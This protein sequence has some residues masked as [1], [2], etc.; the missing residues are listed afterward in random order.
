V[1]WVISVSVLLLVVAIVVAFRLRRAP[2][3]EE[4]KSW[5]SV[6]PPPDFDASESMRPEKRVQ[7]F[8]MTSSMAALE[9]PI[10]DPRDLRMETQA[11][12]EEGE[13]AHDM[14]ILDSFL[15]DVRDSLGADEAVYWRWSK[16]RDTLTPGAWSTPNAQRPQFFDM[17]TW[18]ALV[19][20]AAEGR[21]LSF[22]ADARVAVTRLAAAPVEL[23]GRLIGVLSVARAEGLD[24]GREHLKQW[25]P[26]HAAQVGRLVSLFEVRLQM[27][28]HMRHS[29]AL[30][31]AAQ[32]VQ[33]HKS[34][35]ALNKAICETTLQVTSATEAALVRWR[36]D[37]EKGWVQFA[38][39]GLRHKAPFPIGP[40]S[41]VA[42]TCMNG[43]MFVHDDVA[44][45]SGV[46][47][48][49]DN[50][51]AWTKGALAIV[52]LELEN[53][54]IGAIVA[55]APPKVMIPNEEARNIALLGALA[56]TSL[57]MVWEI[58]EVS[59]RARTDALTGLANRRAFDEQ[60]SQLLA[61]ADRFGHSLS[62]ILADVDHFKNVNDTWGHEAG[63]VVLKHIAKTL[64]DGV[65]AVDICARFGGEEIALLLPQ[66]ALPGA[67]ELADRLR[68]AVGEKPIVWAGND[69]SVTVSCGVA[70]Y[71]DGV[72]TKEALFA[73]ADR[74]LYEAKS[75]GRNRVKSAVPKPTGVAR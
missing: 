33:G 54:V 17:K 10:T 46:S 11:L 42:R 9:E 63:D 59:R 31:R 67:T 23:D 34:Q 57:E 7:Q 27:G 35:D 5:E 38:T 1:S 40:D 47:M 41:L 4:Q 24:R 66:T 48:F 19:K 60:L 22:D 69:I 3:V 37:E 8:R 28:R 49:F 50:D 36:G 14:V 73:A 21:V 6:T 13:I 18:G 12:L 45:M 30:L 61:H 56:A 62:L 20:W 25:L 64:Q 44:K 75:A 55:A 53:R 15:A 29:K 2:P 72:L 74:A 43:T 39:A 65:R 58:E 32:L 70:C 26:R 71:P 52:P 68:V 16:G 51:E